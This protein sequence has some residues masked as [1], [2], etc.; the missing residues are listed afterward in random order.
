[1]KRLLIGC[2][3]F[4]SSLGVFSQASKQVYELRTYE[5]RFGGSRAVLENYF[6]NALFPTLNKYGIKNIGAFEEISKEDPAKLYVLIPYESMES[7]AGMIQK[8]DNDSDFKALSKEY[9]QTPAEK[10][11]Y[12]RYTSSLML[13]FDGF[14]KIQKLTS[15]QKLLEVRIYESHNEG[16]AANKRSMFN[17]EELKI[18]QA[19]N[20]HT[21]FFGQNIIGE[22]L[23]CLTYMLAFDNME[24]RDANWKL[25]GNHPDWKR[26]STDP[27]YS[28]NM[29][30]IRRI[31]LNPL[32]Y[33][34]L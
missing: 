22:Y 5:L 16:T 27:K 13:A 8:I 24:E 9:D 31:F 19:T 17:D 20:L 4:L 2:V 14:P 29:N 6:K 1:M 30:K 18:F 12:A 23:P 33:S 26:I 11:P 32:P 34:Q 7:F 3:L 15:T 21:I 28:G 10:T 25:F